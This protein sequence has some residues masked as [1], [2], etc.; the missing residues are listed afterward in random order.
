MQRNNYYIFQ[1]RKDN[2]TSKKDDWT[3]FLTG[4]LLGEKSKK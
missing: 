2:K 4:S 3:T 1:F